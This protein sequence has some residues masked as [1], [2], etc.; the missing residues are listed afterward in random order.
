MKTQKIINW[1]TEKGIFDQG[2][3][4][5]QNDKLIEEAGELLNA[6]LYEQELNQQLEIGDCLVVSIIIA[7]M[8]CD[9]I[10][11]MQSLYKKFMLGADKA[12]H[13]ASGATETLAYFTYFLSFD[14]KEA[15]KIGRF[16]Y[17][18]GLLAERLNYDLDVCLDLAYNKII[19]RT[20]KM[21]DGTF[22]K[23]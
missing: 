11:R 13:A 20:G 22:K 18:L 2:T 7:E 14:C 9:K 8:K 10:E 3:Q 6:V 12:M 1:A 21:I 23:D 5:A 4:A 19:K 17:A 16:L 15:L